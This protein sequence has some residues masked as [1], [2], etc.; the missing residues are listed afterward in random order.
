[1]TEQVESFLSLAQL[2]WASEN[3]TVAADVIS[4]S[5]FFISAG[6]N[7]LFEY[8][9]SQQPNRNDTEFLQLLVV[10]YSKHLKVALSPRAAFT[11]T[12]EIRN[13]T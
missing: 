1:M 3:R 2:L 9:Y 6:S 11:Q 4:K 10:S 13:R 8:A 5:L 12:K 7:D